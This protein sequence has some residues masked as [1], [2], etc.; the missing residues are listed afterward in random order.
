MNTLYDRLVRGDAA[1]YS[2]S[3]VDTHTYILCRLP[4]HGVHDLY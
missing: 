3:C 1:K 4:L 2:S